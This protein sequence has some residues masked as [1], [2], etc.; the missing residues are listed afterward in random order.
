MIHSVLAIGQSNMA[1]RG[2]MNCEGLIENSKILVLRNGIFR[3][4]SRPVNPDRPFSGVSLT[5]SFADEYSKDHG[6]VEVGIIPCADGGTCLDQWQ[7]GSLLYDNA[8]NCAKLAMR[9]SH[10]VAVL[11]HQGESD[12]HSHRAPFYEEK[13]R[14]IMESLRKD[15]SLGDVPLIMGGLGDYLVNYKGGTPCEQFYKQIN[16]SIEALSK[17]LPKCAYVSAEGLTPNSDNLHFNTSSLYEFGRRYYAAF[18][19]LEDKNRVFEEKPDASSAVR[20][21]MELL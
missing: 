3:P 10:I 13:C 16:A 14:K 17:K 11:W 6:D 15:L 19:E 5:E 20:T 2:F 18:K 9:T 8:V 12:C 4:M 1:G 7:V 21:G